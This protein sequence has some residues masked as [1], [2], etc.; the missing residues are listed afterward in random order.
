M[1][2][3]AKI[4]LFVI[5]AIIVFGYFLIKIDKLKLGGKADETYN[6]VAYFKNVAGLSTNATVRL[7]GYVIGKVNRI[8]LQ[9][10]RVKVVMSIRKSVELYSDSSASVKTI[11]LLGEKYVE[12]SMGPRK[13]IRLKDNDEIRIGEEGGIDALVDVIGDIGADLKEVTA[14]LRKSIGTGE[15]NERMERILNN[16]ERITADL[17]DITR[18][19]KANVDDALANI[20]RIS[21]DLDAK[22]PTISED[23]KILVEDLKEAVKENRSNVK[24]SIENIQK[25]TDRLDQILKKVQEGQGTV[26]K[27]MNES[28]LHDNLNKTIKNLEDTVENAGVIIQQASY[29]SFSLGFRGE[30]YMRG[31]ELKNYISFKLRTWE[32]M[33]FFAE[34]VDDNLTRIYDP[35]Y[36]P[37]SDKIIFDRDMTF[38]LHSAVEFG[39]FVLRGGLTEN[40]FGG[41]MDIFAFNDA[42]RLTLEGWDM[43]RKDGPHFKFSLNYRFYN[44]FYINAGYDDPLKTDR[45]QAFMG[46]GYSWLY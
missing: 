32:N 22:V 29:F 35:E 26:G 1:K 12:V 4:G 23:L 3:E 40:K 43:G 41:A 38:T 37:N 39:D 24:D 21:A 31:E 20:K 7:Q 13:G 18:D 46:V 45:S 25:L 2:T 11:G 9:E 30:Y 17:R 34:L 36:D 15:G 28:T 16:I 14:S 10:G 5:I 44:R 27:L 42:L 19:N 8:G 33:Y 6:V